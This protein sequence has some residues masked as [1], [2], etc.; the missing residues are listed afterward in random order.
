MVKTIRR[1]EISA[2]QLL[3]GDILVN[4]E[5]NN[6][7]LTFSEIS[8]SSLSQ[9]LVALANTNGGCLVVGIDKR[10]SSLTGVDQTNFETL[11][12]DAKSATENTEAS[13]VFTPNVRIIYTLAVIEVQPSK[14]IASSGGVI[15][16]LVNGLPTSMPERDILYR[17]GLG[18][19]SDLINLMA[20][21]LS[22]QS[23]KI[24]SLQQSVDD[25]GKLR[26][27]WKSLL[28]GAVLGLFLSEFWT[29][30]FL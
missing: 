9:Y 11:F 23:S 1:K 12:S 17:L 29:W 22:N 15:Y 5:Q 10:Q 19:D 24:S 4:I 27:Q 26:N 3:K 25:A 2:Q 13:I 8:R 28:T 20:R 30:L 14:A 7:C 6:D 16:E 21:Q 18:I